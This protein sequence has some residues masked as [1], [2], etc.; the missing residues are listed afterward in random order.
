LAYDIL[1]VGDKRLFDDQ[2]SKGAIGNKSDVTK[3]VSD[4]PRAA[5]NYLN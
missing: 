4:T 2:I 3:S 1:H 5:Y